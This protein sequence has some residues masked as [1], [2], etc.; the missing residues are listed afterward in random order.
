MLRT[1]LDSNVSPWARICHPNPT[2]FCFLWSADSSLSL[3]PRVPFDTALTPLSGKGRIINTVLN[4]TI[5]N[6]N[7]LSSLLYTPFSNNFTTLG[8]TS[9]SH[10]SQESNVNLKYQSLRHP[11]AHVGA[12]DSLP[13]SRIWLLLAREL[14][15]HRTA[16]KV[17]LPRCRFLTL[18]CRLDSVKRICLYSSCHVCYNKM[19]AYALYGIQL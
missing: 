15:V 19:R 13:I 6:W 18:T 3:T 16:R 14:A 10:A 12:P 2:F 8:H 7:L 11:Y 9:Y 4:V 17:A 5:L 1:W